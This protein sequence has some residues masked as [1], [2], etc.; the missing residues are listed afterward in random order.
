MAVECALI[1][2]LLGV[3]ISAESVR[4]SKNLLVLFLY[5]FPS[6]FLVGLVPHEP[7][8]IFFGAYHNAWVVALVAVASTVMAEGVNYSL[9][10]VFYATSGLRALSDRKPVAKIM[11][12]F[13]RRPFAAILFAGFTPVP[14][15]PVRFLV[16]MTG[17]PVRRYLWGVFL[18]RA[19]RFWLLAAFGAFFEIP[20]SLLAVLFLVMM[21]AVNI[22]TLA[23]ALIISGAR[24]EDGREVATVPREMESTP[25]L[26]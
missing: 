13:D 11:D 5:S 1:M 18:S 6:E 25:G 20:G 3:W 24:G 21:A 23:R 2:L 26:A 14:F 16:V 22:P 17:Y 19:P 9:F 12:L 10:S 4:A 15:F 7:V 8:L